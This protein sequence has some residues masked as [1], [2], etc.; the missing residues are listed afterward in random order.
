[1]TIAVR[2][3]RSEVLSLNGRQHWGTRH[4]LS[5]ILQARARAAWINAGRPSFDR[6]RMEVTVYYPD[7]R[8]RDLHNLVATVKPMIDGMVRSGMLPDDSD[9]YLDG[10]HMH[11]AGTNGDV[12]DRGMYV[13]VFAIT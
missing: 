13:F 8:R 4:R 9:R 3:P 6:C 11:P 7:G 2:V 10:P 5:G 12:R 1:M